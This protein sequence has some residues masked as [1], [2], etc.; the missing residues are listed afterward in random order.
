MPQ[1]GSLHIITRPVG[2]S[3]QI[4]VKDSGQGLPA[5]NI[6]HIFEPFHETNQPETGLDLSI[7]QAVIERHHGAIEVESQPGQG[8]TFTIHLPERR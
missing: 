3:V 6:R 4:I 2:R 8:T 5:E 1:G 7:T